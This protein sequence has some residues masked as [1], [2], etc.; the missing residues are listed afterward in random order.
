MLAPVAEFALRVQNGARKG[1]RTLP[2]A[3]TRDNLGMAMILLNQGFLS[4][5]SRGTNQVP[6]SPVAW[7]H[8][9]SAGDRRFWLDLKFRTD[10]RAVLEYL[11]LVSKPG[12]KLLFERDELMKL[13]TGRRARYIPPL[14]LGEVGII[15]TGTR[16]WMEIKDAVRVGLGGELVAKAM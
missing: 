15:N 10:D 12:R 4:N 16:G 3:A 8:A 5:V 7:I 14:R 1:V 13:A 2:V 9:P 11:Q 6:H